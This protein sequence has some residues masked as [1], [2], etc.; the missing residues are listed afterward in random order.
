MLVVPFEYSKTWT[1]NDKP[2]IFRRI[3]PAED[4]FPSNDLFPSFD[5]EDRV[6]YIEFERNGDTVFRKRFANRSP[7]QLDEINSEYYIGPEEF[8][9]TID[10]IVWYGGWQATN[11]NKSGVEI[12][13]ITFDDSKNELEA[14]QINRT[15]IKDGD[16]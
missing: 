7:M 5:F 9:G 1:T 3:F 16:Y 8:T 10:D 6:L 11:A 15:D 13:R 12:D 2:N 14:Y 4:L